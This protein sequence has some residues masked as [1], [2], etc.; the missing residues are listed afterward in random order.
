ML[1]S[2]KVNNLQIY[3]LSHAVSMRHRA[4]LRVLDASVFGAQSAWQDAE[5]DSPV[6]GKFEVSVIACVHE[7]VAGFAIASRSDVE[8][9]KL[10]WPLLQ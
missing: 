3:T 1:P 4:A 7:R 10:G 6:P 2:A 8:S 9:V 5:F